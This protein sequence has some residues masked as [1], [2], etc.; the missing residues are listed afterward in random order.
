MEREINTLS[1]EILRE[2]IGVMHVMKK[3]GFKPE[4]KPSH[5]MVLGQINHRPEGTSPSE[6]SEYLG[7]SRSALTAILDS[8]EDAG[9][10]TR[11]L[12]TQDRRKFVVKPTE[13]SLRVHGYLHNKSYEMYFEVIEHL[14]E[15]NAKELLRLLKLVSSYLAEKKATDSKAEK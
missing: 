11:T 4:I 2:V 13:K 14:G 3:S 8:L 9:Y 15:E 5:M 1:I 10:L 7:F 6:I 12:S